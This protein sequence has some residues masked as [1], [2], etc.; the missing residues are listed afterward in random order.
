ME[1]AQRNVLQFVTVTPPSSS[2]SLQ[3]FK[4]LFSEVETCFAC[5]IAIHLFSSAITV[6]LTLDR[7]GGG[8]GDGEHGSELV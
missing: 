7:S 4:I 8:D 5:V 3:C 1:V 6:N 2:S